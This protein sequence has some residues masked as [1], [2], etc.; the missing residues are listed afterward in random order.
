MHL[1]SFEEYVG[2]ISQVRTTFGEEKDQWNYY[3]SYV[4]HETGWWESY[5]EGIFLKHFD[6]KNPIQLVFWESGPEIEL[7]R[8]QLP[9][10]NY[11]F[12]GLHKTIHGTKDKYLKTIYN[13]TG[14]K[15]QKKT[16]RKILE[17]LS[18]KNY[19]IIDLYPT[20][21]IKISGKNRKKFD[22]I[23]QKYTI[24]KL[25]KIKKALGKNA[26]FANTIF[27]PEDL[28]GEF[29]TT[30]EKNKNS[31]KGGLGIAPGKWLSF[32][33]YPTP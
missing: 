18:A 9:H 28:K 22:A 6:K 5:F 26:N 12:Y 4:I 10:P 3:I 14:G 24:L 19:L 25:E 13:I 21:A 8:S 7:E 20:H 17:E 27:I 23:L 31:I 33:I 11:A 30:L 16:K 15:F 2:Y 29:T 1:I 32:K